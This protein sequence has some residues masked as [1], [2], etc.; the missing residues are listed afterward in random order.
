MSIYHHHETPLPT[1]VKK[2]QGPVSVYKLLA[3]VWAQHRLCILEIRQRQNFCQDS[4]IES[5]GT[6]QLPVEWYNPEAKLMGRSA[7]RQ[8]GSIAQHTAQP[9]TSTTPANPETRAAAVPSW[10]DPLANALTAGIPDN[11]HGNMEVRIASI[12]KISFAQN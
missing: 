6:D 5:G 11:G 7:V 2:K 12:E 4:G 10:R 8:S 3:G 1:P 9:E